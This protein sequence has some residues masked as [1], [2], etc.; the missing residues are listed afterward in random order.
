MLIGG[1]KEAVSSRVTAIVA[2]VIALCILVLLDIGITATNG[3]SAHERG[4][5]IIASEA[6]ILQ[7]L[8]RIERKVDLGDEQRERL[9]AGQVALRK[10]LTDAGVIK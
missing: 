9:T 7:Q 8:T 1:L 2:S 4:D 3:G 6:V 10:S 5:K